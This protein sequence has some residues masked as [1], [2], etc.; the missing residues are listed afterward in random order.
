MEADNCSLV[1]NLAIIPLGKNQTKPFEREGKT[2]VGTCTRTSLN[3]K[4]LWKN[5]DGIL[6]REF[7]IAGACE[8]VTA[9]V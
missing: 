5:S 2:D 4:N 8:R 7:A 3:G 9:C 6:E 1:S